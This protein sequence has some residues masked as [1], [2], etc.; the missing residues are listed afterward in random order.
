VSDGGSGPGAEASDGTGGG[1]GG[2]VTIR[3]VARAA[4]V[5]VSTVSRALDPDKRD[6]IGE[7][8]R[9]RVLEVATELGYR[10]HLVASGL[11][12]GQ[13]RT[14]GV[15]VPDLG[16]PIYA[17]F[18]RGTTHALG[19]GGY[20]PFVADTE[21]D[22]AAFER[23][24]RH[25]AERRVEA[26]ISTAAR[27]QDAELLLATVAM[28]VPV[29]TAIRTL[30]ASGL[31]SVDHDDVGGAR[32]AA[33]H[34]VGL[35]HTRLGQVRGPQDVEA[36]RARSVGFREAVQRGGASLAADRA[37]ASRPTVEDGHRITT[38]FLTR[39]RTRPTALFVQNDT[40]AIGALQA[41][42]D[43]G[44][45]CPGD[46]SIVGYND[47]PFA[48]H[49]AP[50]LTTV[51]LD[52]YE[53]GQRAGRLALELIQ[54]RGQAGTERVSVAPDLIVRGSTAPPPD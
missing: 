23:V 45:R 24:L 33:D 7:A 20:L 6:L 27:L 43:L 44:L 47:G 50:P 19:G 46:V 54:H 14:V 16:N 25:L 17:P 31:P 22:H 1:A 32:L 39:S 4:Q 51:R 18:T 3:D 10:P 26:I 38:G 53:I 28:G 41:V 2:P 42:R 30:P 13:T 29:L 37:P 9:A 52:A 8:T 48:P 5:H 15:V 12:R 35:G 36:F 11:R 40:M 21:D 34:L 49:T